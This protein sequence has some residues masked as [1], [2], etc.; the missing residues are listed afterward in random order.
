MKQFPITIKYISFFF[1][2]FVKIRIRIII[3]GLI[4]KK[5]R[6]REWI[7]RNTE[8][9][10]NCKV[11]QEPKFPKVIE[12]QRREDPMITRHLLSK[13]SYQPID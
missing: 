7:Q 6:E 8:L 11:F 10:K 9:C 4:I 3:H 5:K 13:Q 1:I 12:N 2:T